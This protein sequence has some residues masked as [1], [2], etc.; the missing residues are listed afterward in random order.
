MRSNTSGLP[1]IRLERRTRTIVFCFFGLSL[2]LLGT[3][4][5]T[6]WPG[7]QMAF[8]A[9]KDLSAMT[10]TLTTLATIDAACIVLSLTAA[11]VGFQMLS[12]YAAHASRMVMDEPVGVLIVVSG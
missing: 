9:A 5:A 7:L 3:L 11:L 6:V 1:S 8:G 4:A 12:R 10:S 2:G